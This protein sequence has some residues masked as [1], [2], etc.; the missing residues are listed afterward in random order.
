MSASAV[1]KLQHAGF[2][3]DQVETL[4]EF[5]DERTATKEDLVKAEASIRRDMLEM[6]VELIKWYVA[7]WFA[8]AGMV[9]AALKFLG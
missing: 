8:T 6:K 9:I 4:A 3:N 2:T 7:G 5:M 1:L